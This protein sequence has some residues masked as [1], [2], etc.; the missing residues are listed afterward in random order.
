MGQH[1]HKPSLPNPPRRTPSPAKRRWVTIAAGAAVVAAASTTAWAAVVN[2]DPKTAALSPET[3][4]SPSTSSPGSTGAS[5]TLSPTV[6]PTGPVAG[7]VTGETSAPAGAKAT[8]NTPAPS[9]SSSKASSKEVATT[10]PSAKP[11]ATSQAKADK[12]PVAKTKTKPSRVLS[13]GRC[14][15][16]FYA[17]GQMTANGERFNPSAMTAAHKTLPFGSRVRVTNPANGKSVTVRINDRG[18][19]IGGRC[20]D[21]SRA[22]F[23]AIGN[24]GAGVMSVKYAVLSR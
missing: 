8:P 4:P 23:A 9:T 21:L 13:S 17:E 10:P 14:G 20:L 2:D 22:A 24:T 11:V 5:P 6:S 1:S 12:K 7:P 18:P 16:S 19:F 3:S 15:A